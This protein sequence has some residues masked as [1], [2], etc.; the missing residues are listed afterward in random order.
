MLALEIIREFLPY[1]QR[2][3]VIRLIIREFFPEI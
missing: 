3:L 2:I 1:Y